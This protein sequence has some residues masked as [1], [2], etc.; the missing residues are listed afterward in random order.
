MVLARDADATILIKNL[1]NQLKKET[2]MPE[3]AKFVKTGAHVERMPDNPD[4]WYV[5]MA[6]L[7]R[8]IYIDGPVGI[9]K[10]R[11]YYGGKRNRGHKPS[12]FK[13]SGGKII[14]ACLQ[15]LEKLGYAKKEK[16]GRII[17]PKGQK[18]L[19]SVAKSIK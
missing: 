19:D 4:W 10:L 3:W 14:R 7:L 15:E 9:S 12:H 8:R 13:K 5:R 2:K 6:S 1:A 16:K 17:T 11:T 18:F